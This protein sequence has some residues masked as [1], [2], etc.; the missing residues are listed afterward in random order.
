LLA[1][2]AGPVRELEERMVRDLT[3]HQSEQFRQALS[4]AWQALS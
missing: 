3:A 4:K 2:C 1:R